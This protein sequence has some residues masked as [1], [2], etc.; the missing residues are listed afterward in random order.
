M[1]PAPGNSQLP[2]P[3]DV[4]ESGHGSP[5][6]F[7]SRFRPNFNPNVPVFEVGK[8]LECESGIYLPGDFI[9]P[10][11]EKIDGRRFK[12]LFEQRFLQYPS[13]ETIEKLMKDPKARENAKIKAAKNRLD[14]VKAEK[15][16]EEN[17]RKK[18]KENAEKDK[19]NRAGNINRFS[20]D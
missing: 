13:N 19:K 7:K 10:S 6:N 4:V 12:L 14:K 3:N 16:Y 8:K 1:S 17:L 9:F 20:V 5:D 18:A 2:D 11:D 15:E